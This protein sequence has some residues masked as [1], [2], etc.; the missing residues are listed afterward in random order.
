MKALTQFFSEKRDVPVFDETT[1]VNSQ[2]LKESRLMLNRCMTGD[3]EID[4]QAY[5]EGL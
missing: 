2:F 1:K 3:L 4:E 5:T